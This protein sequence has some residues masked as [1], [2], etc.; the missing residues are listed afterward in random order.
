MWEP[1]LSEPLVAKV[2]HYNSKEHSNQPRVI[3]APRSN[4]PDCVLWSD[5]RLFWLAV[6]S[7]SSAIANICYKNMSQN[8]LNTY[9]HKCNGILFNLLVFLCLLHKKLYSLQCY[10]NICWLTGT[11]S[12]QLTNKKL[13]YR[14]ETARQLPTWRGARPSSPL[15]L[16]PLWLH[17]CVWSN[18]KATAF[19]RQACRP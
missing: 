3:R 4:Q 11:A 13:S 2:C 14:R 18:Q 1:W 19:V 17:L 7:N 15:P 10:D 8:V 16:C 12:Q 5:S 6:R 9:G